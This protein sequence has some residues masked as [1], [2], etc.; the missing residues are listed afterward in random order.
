MTT[1]I[2]KTAKKKRASRPLQPL[3]G[4]RWTI[5]T[6]KHP[7]WYLQFNGQGL[8][9]LHASFVTSGDIKYQAKNENWLGTKGKWCGPLE[10]P[11][12]PNDR[13]EPRGTVAHDNPKPL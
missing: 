12:E 1:K 6:P 10:L 8:P 11:K 2:R 4:L 9:G 7:G 5:A 13:G 3:V